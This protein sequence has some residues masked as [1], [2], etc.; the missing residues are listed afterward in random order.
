[1]AK[2]FTTLQDIYKM[3][4]PRDSRVLL[5]HLE[6]VFPELD[7]TTQA[8]LLS[9]HATLAAH[10]GAR[11]VIKFIRDWQEGN[12]AIQDDDDRKL[13]DEGDQ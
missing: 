12:F 1:M 3:P 9:N 7:H 8:Q 4:M 11:S 13:D 10:T 6:Q 5:Q 2:K